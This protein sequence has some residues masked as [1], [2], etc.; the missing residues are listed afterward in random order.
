MFARNISIVL[1]PNTL[2]DFTKTF[3]ND[4]LPM[5]R[6]QSGFRDEILLASDDS[7]NVTAVSLWD[8]K[9][10]SETYVSTTYPAVLKALD[11]FLDSP[12]K[13]RVANVIHSTSHKL[14]AAAVIAA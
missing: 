3:E 11:K 13:V 2:I 6:K 12:P 14:T 5:L 1:K 10:Q 8:T 7:R 9:E 4:V